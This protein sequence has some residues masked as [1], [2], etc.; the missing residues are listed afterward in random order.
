M[1]LET[2]TRLK[3]AFGNLEIEEIITIDREG[4]LNI[5]QVEVSNIWTGL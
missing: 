5:P 1:F 4:K 2:E 3:S